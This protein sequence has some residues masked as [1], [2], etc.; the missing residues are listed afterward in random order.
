M[1]GDGYVIKHTSQVIYAVLPSGSKAYLKY[2]VEGNVMKLIETYTPPEFRG[3][4]IATQ[5][6]DYA[7]NLAQR[8]NWLIEPIC[9]YTVY[10]FMKNREKRGILIERY[11]NLKEEDWKQLFESARIREKNKESGS[12][13]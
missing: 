13:P 4:G 12:A 11:R 8:N 1:H 7:I 6:V 3:R 2:Q 9:S 5:L 10:Y